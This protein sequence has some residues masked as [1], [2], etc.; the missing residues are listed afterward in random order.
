[1][2]GGD[3]P[4]HT[5]VLSVALYDYVENARWHDANIIAAGMVAF[6]FLTIMLLS[7]LQLRTRGRDS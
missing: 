6:S 5:R 1:M 4:G 7:S 2:I 3:I